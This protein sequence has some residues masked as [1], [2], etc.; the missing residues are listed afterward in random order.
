[1]G[2]LPVSSR[3]TIRPGRAEG[4]DLNQKRGGGER[5][6]GC[7][8]MQGGDRSTSVEI[9][10]L[11]ATNAAQSRLVSSFFFDSDKEIVIERRVCDQRGNDHVAARS[12]VEHVL[13]AVAD[14]DVI[15][16]AAEERI[17]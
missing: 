2:S 12:A 3:R 16:V 7:V 15:A 11:R 4:F 10:R 14:E 9:I 5:M 13:P 6:A 8:E 1:M 17:V